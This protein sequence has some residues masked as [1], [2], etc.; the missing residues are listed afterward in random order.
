MLTCLFCGY[1]PRHENWSRHQLRMALRHL[2]EHFNAQHGKALV[3]VPIER[4][5]PGG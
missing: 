4:D 3:T 2:V 1:R 5:Q